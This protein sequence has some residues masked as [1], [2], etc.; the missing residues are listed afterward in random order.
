MENTF[1]P[2]STRA[3][4]SV[5][6]RERNRL[7]FPS[8][9][10]VIVI[11][12]RRAAHL[13]FT[14]FAFCAQ[15]NI[16]FKNI[17]KIGEVTKVAIIVAQTLLLVYFTFLKVQTALR[18]ILKVPQIFKKKCFFPTI[19]FAFFINKGGRYSDI[20]DSKR[21]V[22]EIPHEFMGTILRLISFGK[23]ILVLKTVLNNK[24]CKY[25][26]VAKTTIS[27]EFVEFRWYGSSKKWLKEW[28]SKIEF[29]MKKEY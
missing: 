17:A 9:E 29:G 4:V 26:S 12:W 15:I 27:T 2:F 11:P 21:L 7:S 8:F 14:I 16:I 6:V 25:G 18:P 23:P 28:W 13:A 3:A 10:E 24:I 20:D 22:P 1:L 5:N 19:F